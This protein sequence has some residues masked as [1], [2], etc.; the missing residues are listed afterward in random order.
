MR[1]VLTPLNYQSG[2]AE[3][4]A[5]G[6]PLAWEVSH[7]E[8]LKAAGCTGI[9]FIDATTPSTFR[10]ECA[11]QIDRDISTDNSVQTTLIDATCGSANAATTY[12]PS[13]LLP[14]CKTWRGS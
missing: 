8:P 11:L 14:P 2:G 1:I 13:I 10:V 4:A 12:R 6:W 5:N 3:I 9:R 7:S